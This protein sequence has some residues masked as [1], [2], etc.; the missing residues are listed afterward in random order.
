MPMKDMSCLA[1]P[2]INSEP[3]GGI[4]LPRAPTPSGLCVAWQHWGLSWEPGSAFAQL[5]P[6]QYG[7]AP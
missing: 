4:V 2:W 5:V 1:A 6:K 3:C 7:Q